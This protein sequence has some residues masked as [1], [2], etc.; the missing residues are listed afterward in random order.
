LRTLSVHRLAPLHEALPIADRDLL[1]ATPDRAVALQLAGR[2]RNGWPLHTQHL[3][4]QVLAVID[5]TMA[6][7]ALTAASYIRRSLYATG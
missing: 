4:E 1:P 3:G 7:D 5:K 2:V 6:L